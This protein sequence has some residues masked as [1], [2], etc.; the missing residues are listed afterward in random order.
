MSGKVVVEGPD[1][2]VPSPEQQAAMGKRQIAE[3]LARVPAVQKKANAQVKPDV[4]NPDGSTTHTI[5]LGYMDGQIDLMQFFP[6]KTNVRPG[7]TVVWEMSPSN[8]APHTVTFLN[9]E[10]APDLAIVVPQNNAPP[11]IYFNPATLFPYQPGSELT[12]SG[13]YNSGVVNP[14]PGPFY[15]LKI[16]AMSPGLQPYVCLLHDESGMK[17]TLVI[18]P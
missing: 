10:A 4:K 7:D 8:E 16:G 5:Q 3:Q 6:K 18:L 1:V 12:R 13:A 11:F 17:G 9:G 15:T 14:I 2:N